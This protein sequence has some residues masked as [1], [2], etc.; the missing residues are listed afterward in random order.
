MSTGGRVGVKYQNCKMNF[1]NIFAFLNSRAFLRN[2][3]AFWR[4][5]NIYVF[6]FEHANCCL[7]C[8]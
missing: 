6:D 7:G 5:S 2:A 3:H 1:F 4:A 8:P